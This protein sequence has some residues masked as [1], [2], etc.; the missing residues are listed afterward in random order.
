[1]AFSVEGTFSGEQ[2]TVT[3]DDGQ[4][5]GHDGAIARA[6]E[7]VEEG[8]EVSLTPPTPSYP[9]SLGEPEP[10]LATLQ[11]VF[12]QVTDVGGDYPMPAPPEN[13]G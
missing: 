3:W 6:H 5:S 13:A 9:A 10:A 11:Q 1:M 8:A 2:A 4:L 12:D 7:L